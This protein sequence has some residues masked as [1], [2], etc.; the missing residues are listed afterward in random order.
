M[1]TLKFSANYEKLPEDWQGKTATLIGLCVNG[2]LTK[3]L[4]EHPLF[5]ERDTK[6]RGGGNYAM[7]FDV[8]IILFF[9]YDETGEVFTT[10]RPFSN[11][12]IAYYGRC[13]WQKFELVRA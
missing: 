9:I 6:I 8:G 11:E 2:E 12:K 5:L 4:C 13:L 1:N 7:S 10:I 3:F